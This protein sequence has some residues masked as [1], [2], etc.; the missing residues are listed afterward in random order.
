[1]EEWEEY[2]AQNPAPHGHSQNC[3]QMEAFC[4]RH[5]GH[6]PIALVTSGGTT[7]PLERNTVRWVTDAGVVLL[8]IVLL[9]FLVYAT[10]T[11]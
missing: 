8:C 7:V 6:Y 11:V 9:L 2:F 10:L 1:M 5:V 3:A 4:Q